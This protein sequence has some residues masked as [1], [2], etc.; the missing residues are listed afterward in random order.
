MGQGGPGYLHA[1]SSSETSFI[2]NEAGPQER[3]IYPWA[4]IF[5]AEGRL[6]ER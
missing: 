5:P 6:L 4:F 1:A 3:V 2:K